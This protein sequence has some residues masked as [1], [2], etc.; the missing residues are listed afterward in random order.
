MKELFVWLILCYYFYFYLI[1]VIKGG[2]CSCPVGKNGRCKHCTALLLRFII[3]MEEFN[4]SKEPIVMPFVENIKDK[5]ATTSTLCKSKDIVLDSATSIVATTSILVNHGTDT[6]PLASQSKFNSDENTTHTE[7]RRI[8]P[9]V[10][11][12]QKKEKEKEN[13]EKEDTDQPCHKKQ[14]INTKKSRKKSKSTEISTA[15][16]NTSAHSESGSNTALTNQPKH[17]NKNKSIDQTKES[18]KSNNSESNNESDDGIQFNSQKP[19]RPQRKEVSEKKI[20]NNNSIVFSSP[21]S[22]D[23]KMIESESS[24]SS[25]HFIDDNNFLS[26]ISF[27]PLNTFEKEK[28]EKE[29]GDNDTL[30]QDTSKYRDSDISYSFLSM[31]DTSTPLSNPVIQGST[32]SLVMYIFCFLVSYTL[33]FSFSI[34]SFFL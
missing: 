21:P 12:K 9:W 6:H 7:K 18:Y 16:Y 8:L 5:S 19:R 2:Y 33:H 10:L 13:E 27:L 15:T 29:K 30:V 14:K 4:Q 22:T 34:F 28:E 11:G 20:N 25:K 26:N 24:S 31:D 23:Y 17:K 3:N 1:I 32:V